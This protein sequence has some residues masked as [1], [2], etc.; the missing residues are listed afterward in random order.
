MMPQIESV[1]TGLIKAGSHIVIAGEGTYGE[2]YVI[3]ATGEGAA[4]H[5]VAGEN[6]TITGSGTEDDPFV[7]NAVV[8]Q[9]G[10]V[11]KI[12]FIEPWSG[13][14]TYVK[15]ADGYITL[16]G[17]FSCPSHHESVGAG[18]SYQVGKMPP[19]Y[20]PESGVMFLTF[21]IMRDGSGWNFNH[22]GQLNIDYAGYMSLYMPVDVPDGTS[23]QAIVDGF[24]YWP[25]A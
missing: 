16:A 21:M 14:A 3:S 19:G 4:T 25:G 24:R 1:I 12:Q 8:P 10:E 20:I 2:P 11:R 18:Y 17:S 23:V 13:V 15:D 5:L 7:V 6:V 9:R 22:I